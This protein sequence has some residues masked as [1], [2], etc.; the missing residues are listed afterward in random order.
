MPTTQT[1]P[2]VE[3]AVQ[4]LEALDNSRRGMNI[5]EIGRKLGIPRSTAHVLVLTLER[6]GYVAKTASTRNYM[7]SAKVY[8]LGR[9]TMRN[10]NLAEIALGPMKW[11]SAQA[12]L[13]SHLAVVEGDQ[14]VYI[15]KVEGPGFIRFDTKVGKRTN[16]HC[17]SVGKVL[18]AYGPSAQRREFL[19]KMTYAHY[20]R[21]TLSTAAALRAELDRTVERGYAI[22]DEEE[23]LDVRCLAVPVYNPRGEV[24]AA[25]SLTGTVGLIP[26]PAIS[27]MVGLLQQASMRICCYVEHK[28][29]QDDAG[30]GVSTQKGLQD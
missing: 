24:V 14:A 3:R 12:R 21:K 26:D 15:Q 9:E 4:I 10:Q 5:A 1:V 20:T 13:T 18:L 8:N 23:E 16:L 27:T 25:L 7:L 11:L 19:G 29:G 28:E 2:A 22:D 6:C 30:T 17:T